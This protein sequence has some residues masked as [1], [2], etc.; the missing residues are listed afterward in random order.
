VIYYKGRII[1]LKTRI[2]IMS[3]MEQP[4]AGDPEAIKKAKR[5][6]ALETDPILKEL[7]N[8]YMVASQSGDENAAGYQ[9]KL[10]DALRERGLL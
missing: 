8:V 4:T 1:R 5:E 9:K 7:K 10:H 3:S 2:N 6:L